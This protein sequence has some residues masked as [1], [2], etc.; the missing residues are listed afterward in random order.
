MSI[1]KS[2]PS[3][4]KKL[5]FQEAE[6]HCPFC[7]QSNVD[8]LEIHHIVEQA[9]GG[10]HDPQNLIL[11]CSNCHSRITSGSISLD[12][13]LAMKS[14]LS[15]RAS[16]DRSDGKPA[17]IINI[18]GGEHSGVIANVVH[19]KTSGK[20]SPKLAH[21]QGAIGS[22]LLCRNYAKYLID[23]YNEF[24]RADKT[25]RVF[26]FGVI[27]RTI[28]SRFKANWDFIPIERFSEL[29]SFLQNHIDGT[30]LG[31]IRRKQGHKNYQ[32][33]EEFKTNQA[34]QSATAEDVQ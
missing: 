14:K 5:I 3:K 18:T 15:N 4:T 25:V 1:K 21:P 27:Y 19:L 10:S 33:F 32:T 28:K 22:N 17:N 31:K 23:R 26:S 7:D 8:V 12:E 2:I 29:V 30:I 13:V 24:K 34:S 9:E 16:K 6:S 11:A 20:R